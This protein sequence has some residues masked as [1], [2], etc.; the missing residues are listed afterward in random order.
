M[1]KWLAGL[2]VAG[3][4][5][6]HA[7]ARQMFKPTAPNPGK[8]SAYLIPPG[9]SSSLPTGWTKDNQ[10]GRGNCQ[11]AGAAGRRTL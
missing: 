9:D 4:I 8:L 5:A 6:G 11:L 1:Q 2:C 10:A 3:L 7:G